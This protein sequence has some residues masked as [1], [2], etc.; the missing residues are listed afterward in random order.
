MSNAV[1]GHCAFVAI[2]DTSIVTDCCVIT[3]IVVGPGHVIVVIVTRRFATVAAAAGTA[4]I[5]RTH[6]HIQTVGPIPGGRNGCRLRGR[7][8]CCRAQ[9][10]RLQCRWRSAIDEVAFLIVLRRC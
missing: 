1:A 3:I 6:R 10:I 2:G 7:G 9:Y 8:H 5:A 4:T